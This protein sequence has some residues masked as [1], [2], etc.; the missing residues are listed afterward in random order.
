MD[1]LV[2]LIQELL[3]SSSNLL[4]GLFLEIWDVPIYHLLEFASEHLNT[5]E[6]VQGV[7]GII[8]AVYSKS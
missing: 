8:N 2:G 4:N 3:L 1:K 6:L 7:L 5:F